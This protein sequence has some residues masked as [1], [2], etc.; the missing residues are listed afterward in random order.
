VLLFL[1]LFYF[2]IFILEQG[3]R[4]F[5]VF[6]TKSNIMSKLQAAGIVIVSW[7]LPGRFEAEAALPVSL[8]V[9]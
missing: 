1:Y 6:G 4:F 7:I 2:I 3:V 8:F 9:L 5:V